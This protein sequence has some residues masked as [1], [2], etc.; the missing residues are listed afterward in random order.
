MELILMERPEKRNERLDSVTSQQSAESHNQ[1]SGPLHFQDNRPQAIAQKKL[2]QTSSN[3]P[4][5]KSLLAIQLMANNRTS[6]S[7]NTPDD[8]YGTLIMRTSQNSNVAPIQRAVITVNGDRLISDSAQVLANVT[9]ATAGAFSEVKPNET[10]HIF[11]HGYHSLTKPSDEHSKTNLEPELMGGIKAADLCQMMILE[12]WDEEHKGPIDLRACMS[13]AESLLP[14]FAELFALELKKVGRSNMVTG[15]KELSKTEGDGSEVSKKPTISKMIQMAQSFD[16]SDFSDQLF[17]ME[18]VFLFESK[19]GALK[20]IRKK[21]DTMKIKAYLI[22]RPP[23]GM[24]PL[25]WNVYSY[26]HA[27]S[28]KNM[29]LISAL[30]GDFK[31][32]DYQINK[33]ENKA[34]D[35]HFNPDEMELPPEKDAAASDDETADMLARLE[36]L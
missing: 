8:V 1:V 21:A 32:K 12:G 26:Y 3:S 33:V 13:G 5:V 14:S 34:H 16:P 35:R 2:Q 28:E 25:E 4:Q 27:V 20:A 11:A 17:A 15:Y 18:V 29:A 22:G 10:I 24:S 6:T 30:K 7:K 9:G 36:G 31:A 23:L 19:N